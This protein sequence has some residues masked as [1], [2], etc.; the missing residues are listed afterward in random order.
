MTDQPTDPAPQFTVR[1]RLQG[2]DWDFRVLQAEFDS[3][4]PQIIEDAGWWL[5]SA[6]IDRAKHEGGSAQEAAAKVLG[7]MNGIAMIRHS[8]QRLVSISN[9][10]DVL[11]PDGSRHLF[12]E[13]TD[14]VTTRDQVLAVLEPEA[15][16]T[17]PPPALSPSSVDILRL[18]Q[19]NPEVAEA[20][21]FL[22]SPSTWIDLWKV[23]E[24]VR[25][26]VGGEP[27][28]A[29]KGYGTR[30][31]R[32]AFRLSAN[33]PKVSG[34]G[35]RHARFSDAGEHTMTLIEG[36]EFV[37]WLTDRWIRRLLQG[38]A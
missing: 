23:Y 22:A 17:G 38:I 25:S 31:Q 33:S 36:R 34:R 21:E 29:K 18:A 24:V 9:R 13:F 26:S 6:A 30:G 19:V 37:R 14:D 8:G 1:V 7:L 16:N 27:G 4:D 35:A 32:I 12:I 28:L 20:L 3:P 10:H 2:D 11:R 15:P 5:S